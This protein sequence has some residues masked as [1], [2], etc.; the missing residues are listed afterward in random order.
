MGTKDEK[1]MQVSTMEQGKESGNFRERFGNAMFYTAQVVGTLAS[2]LADYAYDQHQS[3]NTISGEL[4]KYLKDVKEYYSNS[5]PLVAIQQYNEVLVDRMEV[6]F[7]GYRGRIRQSGAY[8]GNGE[9]GLRGT[10]VSRHADL[11]IQ[12]YNRE[13]KTKLLEGNFGKESIVKHVREVTQNPQDIFPDFRDNQFK[14]DYEIAEKV[15]SGLKWIGIAVQTVTFL[16]AVYDI[17]SAVQEGDNEARENAIFDVVKQGMFTVG[18]YAVSGAAW[19]VSVPVMATMMVAAH[20]VDTG[21]HYDEEGDLNFDYNIGLLGLE[22]SNGSFC[23][24]DLSASIVPDWLGTAACY[25]A[26]IC[27]SEA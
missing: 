22:L 25:V 13:L 11:A 18:N 7:N 4:V 6:I 21:L 19:Y 24:A 8:V 20:I 2:K 14:R 27:S 10:E 15:G 17:Y 26:G 3:F 1:G 5:T 12:D 9:Y 16:Y 23:I